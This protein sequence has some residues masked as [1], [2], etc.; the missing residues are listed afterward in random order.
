MLKRSASFVLASL[1]GSTCRSVGLTSSLSVA[2]LDGLFEYPEAVRLLCHTE[3][4]T[5]VV[6]GYRIFPHLRGLCADICQAILYNRREYS[7][8]KGRMTIPR[9]THDSDQT[10]SYSGV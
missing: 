10:C 6:R 7:K 8:T 3:Y 4:V 1:R 9:S 2:L 5:R